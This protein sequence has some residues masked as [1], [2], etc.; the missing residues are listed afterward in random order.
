VAVRKY[1]G[2]KNERVQEQDMPFK[3]IPPV[4]CFLQLSSNFLIAQ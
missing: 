3:G 4:T 1:R 2:K